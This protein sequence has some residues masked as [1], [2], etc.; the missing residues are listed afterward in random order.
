M[1][2][3]HHSTC[4]GVGLVFELAA[5]V[6]ADMLLWPRSQKRYNNLAVY[7]LNSWWNLLH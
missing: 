4:F 6:M 2:A 1:R 5:N 7:G 3:L